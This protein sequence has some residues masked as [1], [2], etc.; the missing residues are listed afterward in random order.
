MLCYVIVHLREVEVEVML[1][2]VMLCYVIVHLREV[3]V[4]A[5]GSMAHGAARAYCVHDIRNET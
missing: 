5:F 3:E 2:Y 4:E 1:R